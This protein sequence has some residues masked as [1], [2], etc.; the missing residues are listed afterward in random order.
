MGPPEVADIR[1]VERR[2][3]ARA[4]LSDAGIGA[5]VAQRLGHNS[6]GHEQLRVRISDGEHF[7]WLVVT[8]TEPAE[9]EAVEAAVERR[10]ASLPEPDR[11]DALEALSPIAYNA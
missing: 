9:A 3:V 10:S 6:A 4:R 2:A 8:L 5:V 11:L 7:G 1:A